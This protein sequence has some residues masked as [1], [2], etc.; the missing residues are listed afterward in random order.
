M[1]EIDRYINGFATHSF[2]DMA[3]QDYIN[4]RMCYKSELYPQFFWAALQALEKYYKAILLYNRIKAKNVGHN[5][6]KAQKLAKDLPF[7][8]RLSE[9]SVEFIDEINNCGRF[10]YLEI[11]YEAIGYKLGFLDKTVWELRR[12]CRVLNYFTDHNGKQ[13]TSVLQKELQA[14]IEA[15]KESFQKFHIN[16]GRLE[17]I[18]K[19]KTTSTTNDYSYCEKIQ[20]IRL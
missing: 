20:K 6:H 8:I 17:Q 4:A 13:N 16:N 15:E 9:S 14:N 7:E 2:R 18:L 10:R 11:P 3:D 1:E 5:L 19:N 12:Y